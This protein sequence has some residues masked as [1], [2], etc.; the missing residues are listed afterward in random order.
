MRDQISVLSLSLGVDLM[1]LKFNG[2]IK[3]SKDVLDASCNFRTNAITWEQNNFLSASVDTI[4]IS[5]DFEHD[6]DQY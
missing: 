4:K 6:V 5:G 1:S 2:Y 3:C